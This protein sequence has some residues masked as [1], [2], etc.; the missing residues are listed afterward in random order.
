LKCEQ[1]KNSGHNLCSN[2]REP[3]PHKEYISDLPPE[4]YEKINVKISHN[5][6][7]KVISKFGNTRHT[8][9]AKQKIEQRSTSKEF[10]PD[11]DPSGIITIWSIQA[12]GKTCNEK[13]LTY[14]GTTDKGF[15]I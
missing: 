15:Q 13:K 10:C 7:M 5:H 2:P 8:T 11:N 12:R 6:D 3:K 14:I 4:R 1:S 9:Q